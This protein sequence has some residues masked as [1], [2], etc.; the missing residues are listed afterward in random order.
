MKWTKA[1]LC[2]PDAIFSNFIAQI[3]GTGYQVE[4]SLPNPGPCIN[5][6][7]SHGQLIVFLKNEERHGFMLESLMR[8]YEMI[9]LVVWKATF[10]LGSLYSYMCV[11]V[12]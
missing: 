4:D 1:R 12:F 2:Q 6:V 10:I 11:C 3:A 7:Y 9:S 5:W 8:K